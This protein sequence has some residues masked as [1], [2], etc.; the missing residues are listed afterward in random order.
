MAKYNTHE[1]AVDIDDSILNQALKKRLIDQTW[2][3]EEARSVSLIKKESC[4]LELGGCIG[5][6]S[7]VIN[8]HISNPNNQVV[9]HLPLRYNHQW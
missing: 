5:I 3:S 2:E 4:V 1:V 8:K 9:C 6:V 7:T